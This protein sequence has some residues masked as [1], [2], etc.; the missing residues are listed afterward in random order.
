LRTAAVRRLTK[1]E[2]TS[3]EFATAWP[4]YDL[5]R[6][7]PA[8]LSYAKKVTQVP[9]MVEEFDIEELRAAGWDER[10]S[11]KRRPLCRSAT[12]VVGRKPLRGYRLTEF[13][14]RQS[15]PKQLR[16]DQLR[17]LAPDNYQAMLTIPAL[18]L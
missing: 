9:G 12:S 4:R 16:V 1:H 18:E 17:R 13:Q 11:T 7:T 8:L 14:N 3:A 5:D 2:H 10:G 6:K 15:F